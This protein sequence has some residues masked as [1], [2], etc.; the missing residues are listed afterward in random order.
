MQWKALSYSFEFPRPALAM[1]I[2]NVTPDSFSDGGLYLEPGA[3]VA[4]AI[5]MIREGAEILDIGGES[6]RPG[7]DPI[8][9]EEELRRI[10][11]VIEALRSQVR[12]PISVDTRKPNVAKA[13]I[14]AGASIVND[15]GG[16][17]TDAAM[18]TLLKETGAGYICMHM[19]GDPTS[20]QVA[21][22]YQDVVAEVLAWFSN[23]LQAMT[24]SGLSTQQIAFDVGIGFGKTVD[25]NLKLLRALD[26]FR[27]L[28]RPLVLGVSRKSFIGKVLGVETTQR[29]PGALACA[30]HAVRQGVA[31]VRT[32]DV[33]A[34]VQAVRM[35]EHLL[36]EEIT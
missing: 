10:L 36:R 17:T 8:S 28:D 24:V 5:E 20:M 9:E 35:T 19:Q 4:H 23:R 18:W 3:A 25:H 16:R 27:I 1:G 34:T 11:P 33:A 21:P 32:H 6:T 13:A 26:C 14:Q 22:H 7:A 30:C 31:V 12:V 29:L 2:L 15:I